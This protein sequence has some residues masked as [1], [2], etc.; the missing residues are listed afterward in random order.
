M[1]AL[2][3]LSRLAVIRLRRYPPPSS[4]LDLAR[5]GMTTSVTHVCWERPTSL[6]TF[7]SSHTQ[8]GDAIIQKL[9]E[10]PFAKAQH[11]INT[12]DAQPGPDGSIQVLVT[13]YIKLDDDAAQIFAESFQLK[14]DGGSYYIA[15][16]IFKLIFPPPNP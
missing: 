10:L 7:E 6:H 16:N 9:T 13:G 12:T 11:V 8:G 2:A 4:G 14:P 5:T 1:Q 3:K 15:H